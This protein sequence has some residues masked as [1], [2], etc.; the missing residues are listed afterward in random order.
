MVSALV[1]VAGPRAVSHLGTVR[2][3]GKQYPVEISNPARNFFN[4]MWRR[5]GSD[6]DAVNVKVYTFTQAAAPVDADHPNL[7]LVTGDLWVETDDDNELH[8]WSGSAWI[9]QRDV[10]IATAQTDATTGITNA[11]A[12]HAQAD[13]S[14]FSGIGDAMAWTTD[15]TGTQP[16]NNDTHDLEAVFLD[17]DGTEIAT[18]LLRGTYTTAADTIAVTAVSTTGTTT[19]Y[20]LGSSDGTAAVRAVVTESASEAV[21]TLSWSFTDLTVQ[22]STPGSGGGK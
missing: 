13:L 22:G 1:K 12:A 17:E 16:T 10:G 6:L 20:D 9:T 15:E 5:T 3:N 4:D 14:G 2:I 18:R 19:T 11:A 21:C 7:K 8:R